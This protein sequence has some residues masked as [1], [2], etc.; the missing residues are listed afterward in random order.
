[1]LDVITGVSPGR[2]PPRL[3]DAFRLRHRIFVEERRWRG[4]GGADGLEID[5]FDGPGAV[6]F[7]AHHGGEVVGHLRLLPTTAPHLLSEVHPFLARRR[8]ATGPHVWEASRHA[9]DRPYRGVD[10][11]F[12]LAT[13]LTVGA[14]EW[15]L[16][17]GISEWIVEL[18]AGCLS[19][20]LG[21]GYHITPLGLPVAIDDRQVIAVH[22]ACDES[23]IARAGAWRVAPAPASPPERLQFASAAR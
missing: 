2:A 22:I 21:L 9:V 18:D 11:A 17:H 5:E 3:V 6:Y 19:R 23:V 7:I 16:A 12:P 1:M 8:Y 15:S 20:L 4:L 14:L 13:E 10:A